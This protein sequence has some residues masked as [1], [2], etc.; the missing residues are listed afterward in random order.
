MTLTKYY[1]E[2]KHLIYDKDAQNKL[3]EM[4]LNANQ[5]GYEEGIKIAEKITQTINER[6]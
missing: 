4:I 6:A 5:E 3:M 1:I 2:I